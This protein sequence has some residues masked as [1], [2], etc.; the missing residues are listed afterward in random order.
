MDIVQG[1]NDYK[2][3]KF[4]VCKN[5]IEISLEIKACYVLQ[6]VVISQRV[7]LRLYPQTV[8]YYRR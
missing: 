7:D 2:F 8:L 5:F 3:F 1:M 6:C 4:A